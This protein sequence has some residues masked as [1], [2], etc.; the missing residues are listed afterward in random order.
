MSSWQNQFVIAFLMANL[1]IFVS[2]LYQCRYRRNGLG[3][4]YPLVPLGIFVWADG[5][6]F[7]LFWTLSSLVS[8]LL[9]DWILFLLIFSVFWLVRSVGETIYYFNQQFSTIKRVSGKALPGYSMFGDDYTIWFVYQI[10]AQVITVVSIITTVYL[11]H[12]WLS[13]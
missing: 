8:L 5:V 11:F 7:G 1:M 12:R 10:V 6:V 2:A 9:G 4:T 3:M 13:T